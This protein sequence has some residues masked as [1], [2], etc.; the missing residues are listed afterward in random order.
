MV[1]HALAP[2]KLNLF[3]HITGQRAD[4][5]HLL[6]TVFQFIDLA[7][8]LHFSVGDDDKIVVENPQATWPMTQDLVFKAATLLQQYATA[9]RGVC[10]VVQKNIPTGAGLGGGSSD[11]ATTLLALNQLWH[12]G[13]SVEK[14]MALGLTLGA[15][16][17]VFVHGHAAWAEG[18]GEQLQPIDLPEPW[19][20]VLYPQCRV[21]TREI[22]AKKKL[23]RD[24][25]SITIRAFL[26]G[27]VKN[28]CQTVVCEDYPAVADAL[29][30][31]GQF[32][33]AKL[34][35]T[36]ACVFAPFS[37]RLAAQSALKCVPVSWT[38]WVTQGLNRS[39]ANSCWDIAKR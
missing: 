23:T 38:A 34:T 6:Q 29:A 27:Q 19:Y 14:L 8:E 21:N 16:V 30:W 22:F 11:A 17:P 39:P 1:Y 4:G 37:S 18:V 26:A 36:G 33:P 15:D 2:A 12:L 35:G 32:A 9:K 28:D 3:L 7:D 31:L 20:L 24:T 5:Y 25:K 10:I 13:F